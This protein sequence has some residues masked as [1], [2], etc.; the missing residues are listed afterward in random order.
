[1]LSALGFMSSKLD[2]RIG[3]WW[4]VEIDIFQF[5]A[6]SGGV[7]DGVNARARCYS[8]LTHS[9]LRLDSLRHNGY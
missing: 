6:A 5:K 8:V 1:M 9:T 3:F 2:M 4:A 7:P